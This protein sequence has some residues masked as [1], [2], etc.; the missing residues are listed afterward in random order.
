MVLSKACELFMLEL[1]SK[2][3]AFAKFNE[4]KTIRKCDVK[5]SINQTF[6]FDFLLDTVDNKLNEEIFECFDKLSK[7]LSIFVY[8]I[9]P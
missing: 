3:F 4:R 2:S 5:E 6:V 9:K 8:L 1:A 7:D